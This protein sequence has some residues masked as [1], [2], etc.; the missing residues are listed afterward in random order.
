[1][2]IL[3][4]IIISNLEDSKTL[5]DKTTDLNTRNFSLH[6]RYKGCC[7]FRICVFLC[8]FTCVG[9]FVFWQLLCVLCIFRL[10]LFLVVSTSAINCLERLVSEMTCYVSSGMLNPAH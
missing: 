2:T 1:M 7:C 10:L 8:V 9:S 3:T 5:I 4:L 6:M